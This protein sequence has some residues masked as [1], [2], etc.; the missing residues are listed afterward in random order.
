MKIV[1]T[2][3]ANDTGESGGHQAGILIPKKGEILCF[4]PELDESKKNPRKPL[5]FFDEE[6][7]IWKFS[8][9]YYNNKFFGGTRNEYRLTGMTEY[10]REHDAHSGDVL[11]LSRDD[12]GVHHIKVEKSS[13]EKTPCSG[14]TST[15]GI[16]HITASATWK[17]IQF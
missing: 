1:K 10:L 7:G 16:Y 17:V 4:F 9:I 12:N 3:S 6:G 11:E 13:K 2:L 8:F 14:A 15:D 5:V